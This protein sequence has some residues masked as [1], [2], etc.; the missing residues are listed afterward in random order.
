MGARASRVARGA[1]SPRL[2]LRS[3]TVAVEKK[4]THQHREG[5]APTARVAPSD[6]DTPAPVLL[7][8]AVRKPTVYLWT[9]AQTS[10]SSRAASSPRWTPKQVGRRVGGSQPGGAR[11]AALPTC[12]ICLERRVAFVFPVVHPSPRNPKDC[13]PAEARS[14]GS[15]PS[16]VIVATWIPRRSC[17]MKAAN[18]GQGAWPTGRPPPSHS[19]STQASS[20][21]PCYGD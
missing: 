3:R 17:L 20:G 4:G 13:P 10:F 6:M 16:L 5:E 19:P 7:D 21:N 14:R 11:R 12:P 1:V 9:F 2:L 8:P 18:A 15:P